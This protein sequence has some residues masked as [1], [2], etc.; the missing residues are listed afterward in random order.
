MKYK[1]RRYY[2]YYLGRVAAY[3]AY[4]LPIKVSLAIAGFLGGVT[5]RLLGKYRN[6]AIEN[7][8]AALGSEKSPAEIRAIALRVF[9]NIAKN[10]VELLNFPRLTKENLSRLVTVKNRDALD[11]AFKKGKGVIILTAHFGNWELVGVTFRLLGCPGQVIGRRIYFHKYDEFLNSLRRV[12]DVQVIYRD[13]SP[14]KMLKVLKDNTILG[15]LADQDVDSVDGV[16]VNFFARPAYTPMGPV[17]LA[18]VSGAVI[19]PTLMIR[20]S[21]AHHTLMIENPVELVDTGNKEADLITNTQKWSDVIES[22]I[23]KYPEQ[24]VWMHRRWKTEKSQ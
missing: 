3:F 7:L 6:I 11:A 5:F 19:L 24:W 21:D 22:Y 9:E 20:E 1:F 12:H 2:L 23:R 4:L 18:R 14:K 17:L 15:I 10:S 8:T 16:F 13:D